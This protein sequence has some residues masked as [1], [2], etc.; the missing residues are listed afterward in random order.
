MHSAETN[1]N[2]HRSGAAF[3]SGSI[4]HAVLFYTAGELVAEHVPGYPP[5]ADKNGLWDR[6]WPFP[7]RSLIERDW[8]P[9]MNGSV[10]LQQSLTK[11]VN[12]LAS[13]DHAGLLVEGCFFC[14]LASQRSSGV[15][16]SAALRGVCY[17]D[18]APLKES[19]QAMS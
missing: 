15:H 12:D 4:W 8:K 18:L 3:H 19:V 2:A 16:Q 17:A 11:L 14:G 1:L 7:D 13:T 10:T 5:Y 9:H 6:A